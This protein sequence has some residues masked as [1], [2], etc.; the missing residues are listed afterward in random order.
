MPVGRGSVD[1]I[2]TPDLD[3]DLLRDLGTAASSS[4][5]RADCSLT[6]RHAAD[7]APP[8]ESSGSFKREL[9][10]RVEPPNMPKAVF[11][12]FCLVATLVLGESCG[13][14]TAA[15]LLLLTFLCCYYNKNLWYRGLLASSTGVC[16]RAPALA[17][18]SMLRCSRSMLSLCPQ[19]AFVSMGR[20][21]AD[22][23]PVAECQPATAGVAGAAPALLRPERAKQE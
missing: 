7:A 10:E 14:L 20:K 4:G 11:Q 21:A 15:K 1:D 22:A 2:M 23:Y 8:V 9:S 17:Q 13:H 19:P 3:L 18:A 16:L 12:N 6:A 5:G